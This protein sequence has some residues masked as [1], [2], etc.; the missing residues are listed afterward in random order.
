MDL[1]IDAVKWE[2]LSRGLYKR[3]IDDDVAFAVIEPV[4]WRL[5]VNNVYS[6]ASPGLGLE[7]WL[8]QLVFFL[9]NNNNNNRFKLNFGKNS[10][11]LTNLNQN[12]GNNF[13]LMFPP[14]R[15]KKRGVERNSWQSSS[16][17]KNRGSG[18]TVPGSDIYTTLL[19]DLGIRPSSLF[20]ST[21]YEWIKG[22]FPWMNLIRHSIWSNRL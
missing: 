19:R 2:S 18:A 10:N 8:E 3:K 13:N 15:R 21:L 17:A 6:L 7:S 1:T 9:Q 12:V 11:S 5:P 22:K 20:S 4:R 16:S 14:G